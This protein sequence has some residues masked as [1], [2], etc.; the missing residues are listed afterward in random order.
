M[1]SNNRNGHMIIDM[2]SLNIL[3]IGELGLVCC[4]VQFLFLLIC[5]PPFVSLH[6]TFHL[7]KSDFKQLE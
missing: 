1:F 2:C 6:G 4:S 5:W 3:F 7:G